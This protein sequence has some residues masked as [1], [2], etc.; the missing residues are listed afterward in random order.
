MK[1]ILTFLLP[2]QLLAQGND[3]LN[4]SELVREAL[5]NNPELK[6]FEYNRD[7]M[8]LRT[9]SEGTLPDPEFTYMR[10]EMPRFRWNAAM[11]EKFGLLQTL[12]FPGKL[13]TET[14]I[15]EIRAEHA[16]HEHME[17][18][19]EVLAKLRSMY[20]ELWFVQ[21]SI[22]LNR[23]NARLLEQFTKIAQTRYG[24]GQSP[25]QDVLKAFVEMAKLENQLMTLR[26]Q[27]LSA[28]AM[29]MSLLGRSPL[30]TLGVAAVPPDIRSLPTL[31]TLHQTAYRYRGMLLH[32]SLSVE[33]GEKMKSL[34]KKE[35]LPDFRLGIEYLR[36][37]DNPGYRAWSVSAG[38]TLPFAPWSLG[39]TS[40][41]VEEA[42]IGIVK[43][44]ENLNN[45][46]NMIRAN[47][48]DL[49]FRAESFARQLENY[50]AVIVPQTEQAL[51]ASMMAYQTGK[52]DFLMLIDSYRM[53]VDV[54]MEKLMLRMQREQAVAE[55]K[56]EVGYAGIF[57][58]RD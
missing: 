31:D 37:P 6:A 10:E 29:L 47:I 27:E 55:L 20:F 12:P 2:L 49:Y 34:A 54:T 28:K 23:E 9:E 48:S 36:M 46:R 45:S 33:E 1:C 56:R 53:L 24:V 16:H 5:R 11:M 42:S 14:E 40:A 15:A 3:T 7:M 25:Q 4:L 32:D 30:D 57:E 58:K 17:R 52:T 21:Q 8:E 18:A 39:R 41:K 38:I 43:A 19:N 35:Y 13:S 22:A 44:R 50:T 26:Q 51:Q